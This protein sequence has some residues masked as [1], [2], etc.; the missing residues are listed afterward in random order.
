MSDAIRR[1]DKIF[2]CYCCCCCWFVSRSGARNE[3]NDSGTNTFGWMNFRQLKTGIL[4]VYCC[5]RRRR[6]FWNH[7]SNHHFLPISSSSPLIDELR[8]KYIEEFLLGQRHSVVHHAY[9]LYIVP[10]FEKN[11]LNRFFPPI[12]FRFLNLFTRSCLL[13]FLL[14][15]NSCQCPIHLIWIYRF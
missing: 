13:V 9:W 5:H 14:I 10:N 1:M 15:Y 8:R 7:F 6:Y 12:Q 4:R 11:V 3:K 2:G